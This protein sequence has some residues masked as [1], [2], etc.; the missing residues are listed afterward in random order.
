[1]VHLGLSKGVSGFTKVQVKGKKRS[2]PAIVD[3][4]KAQAINLNFTCS[5]F[6]IKPLYFSF[7]FSISA[8]I[9]QICF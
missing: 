9:N 1:V 5:V 6:L 4:L 8:V 7:N 3:I 2:P